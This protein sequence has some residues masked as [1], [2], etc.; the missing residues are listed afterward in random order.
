MILDDTGALLYANAQA[1]AMLRL[2]EGG[3]ADPGGRRGAFAS[4]ILRPLPRLGGSAHIN[5]DG[6]VYR[7]RMTP[8]DAQVSN[9]L[10]PRATLVTI[11]ASGAEP[12]AL[13]SLARRYLLTARE[14]E[15]LGFLVLGL[16]TREIAARMR[17]SPNTVKSFLRLVQLKMGVATR[18]GVMALLFESNSAQGVEAPGLTW[19][20]STAA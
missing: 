9:G 7:C 16:P 5:W 1:L 19:S 14:Q 13:Q 4:L 3:A 17:I 10:P 2:Q 8:L 6:V 15:A 11:E 18:M 20:G 12:S